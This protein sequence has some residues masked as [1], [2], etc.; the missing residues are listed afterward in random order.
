MRPPRAS[1]AALAAV[2]CD[3]RTRDNTYSRTRE[4]V[5]A[6]LVGRAADIHLVNRTTNAVG[7]AVGRSV[8][9][10]SGV[11]YFIRSFGPVAAA[12]ARFGSSG[13]RAPCCRALG[14]HRTHV[15][16]LCAPN[17]VARAR[18]ELSVYSRVCGA[19]VRLESRS[20]KNDALFLDVDHQHLLIRIYLRTSRARR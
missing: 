5:R 6:H 15:V 1:G 14:Q 13:A 11:Q 19:C 4:T 20:G 18:E 2:A 16:G 17:A 10:R 3:V 9:Q 8:G 12:V 7:R